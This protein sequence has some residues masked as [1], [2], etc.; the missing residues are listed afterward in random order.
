MQHKPTALIAVAQSRCKQRCHMWVW[1]YVTSKSTFSV[2]ALPTGILHFSG[3][4]CT[5][6]ETKQVDCNR[7]RC[8][9]NGS[10][11]ACT[12][13]FCLDSER[14]NRPKRQGT[15]K[16]IMYL[17]K[18]VSILSSTCNAWSFEVSSRRQVVNIIMDGK[19]LS[20]H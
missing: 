13:R 1:L 9:A 20:S 14:H 4:R 5:P 12:R 2:W 6:G 8:L 11:F 16:V 10:G 3:E 7:C 18:R 17:Q 19:Y 15:N